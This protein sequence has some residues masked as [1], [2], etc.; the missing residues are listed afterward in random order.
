M[1]LTE[2]QMQTIIDVIDGRD[3]DAQTAMDVKHE[4]K[5][6]LEIAPE[7]ALDNEDVRAM[8]DDPGVTLEFEFEAGRP[9][10]FEGVVIAD[11]PESAL[12]KISSTFTVSV[13]ED[14]L[15]GYIRGR[16]IVAPDD[17]VFTG[18]ELYDVE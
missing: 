16:V 6:A 15:Y 12:E 11:S 14:S 4:L 1:Q 13:D 17:I 7:S 18:A 10:Y 3:A 9:P 2:S 8:I 5:G